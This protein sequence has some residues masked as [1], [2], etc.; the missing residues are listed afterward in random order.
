[1]LGFLR[2]ARAHPSTTFE[3]W[4]FLEKSA[5]DHS[6]SEE[7]KSSS[8][9]NCPSRWCMLSSNFGYYLLALTPSHVVGT[10]T[11]LWMEKDKNLGVN[12]RSFKV[13]TT[14]IATLCF[15]CSSSCNSISSVYLTLQSKRPSFSI[16]TQN[17][18]LTNVDHR[19]LSP[20][21]IETVPDFGARKA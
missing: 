1:M 19:S 12:G 7:D 11:P 17:Q 16:T 5:S 18:Y 14:D 21:C 6:S 13:Q 8:Q 15:S 3:T 2:L 10:R 9:Q 4:D 20:M